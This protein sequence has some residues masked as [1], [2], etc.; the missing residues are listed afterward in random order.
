MSLFEPRSHQ[1]KHQVADADLTPFTI[2]AFA[3]RISPSFSALWIWRWSS[4][5]MITGCALWNLTKDEGPPDEEGT[6]QPPRRPED[7][8]WMDIDEWPE[9]E[10][11]P[12]DYGIF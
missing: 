1:Q 5:F 2:A 7:D 8:V 12:E 6:D 9:R 10:I 11:N 4:C 3:S